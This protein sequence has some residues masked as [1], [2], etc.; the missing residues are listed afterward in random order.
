MNKT[1]TA[2][3]AFGRMNPPTIGH[4]KLINTIKQIPGDHFLFL[5]HSQSPMKDPLDFKTKKIFAKLF[6]QNITIGHEN[7]KTPIEAMQYLQSLG[8]TDI[9]FVAGSDRVEEFTK[10]FNMYNKQPDKSG[11]IVFDFNTIKVISAGERNDENLLNKI[12]ATQM[13]ESV[14]NNNFQE[15]VIGVPDRKYAKKLYESLEIAMTRKNET[16]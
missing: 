15:F 11:K 7:I 10:L 1:K 14:K 8:Y 6:F 2:V 13:R 3:F 4:L 16:E 9:V 12:S 5:S